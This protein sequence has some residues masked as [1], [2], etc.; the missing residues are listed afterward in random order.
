M[1]P[2]PNRV[3][4]PVP[5]LTDDAA[6]DAPK[7]AAQDAPTVGPRTSA[8]PD[9]GG[10][11][12]YPT[13]SPTAEPLAVQLDGR[14]SDALNFA[15]EQLESGRAELSEVVG[16]LANELASELNATGALL[17]SV[18]D[19]VIG[20]AELDL[21]RADEP[22]NRLL[23]NIVKAA[24]GELDTLMDG[25]RDVGLE[26]PWAAAHQAMQAEL[27]VF[28]Q[29]AQVVPALAKFIQP[30]AAAEPLAPTG[31][32]DSASV[33]V[34]AFAPPVA[35][36]VPPP[37]VHA[38]GY[39]STIVYA[40]LP[41]VA[42][43]PVPLPVPVPGYSPPPPPPPPGAPAGMCPPPHVTV[44]VA[45]APVFVM[46]GGVGAVPTAPAG[47]VPE[48][49]PPE[50]PVPPAPPSPLDPTGTARTPIQS[51]Y[52]QPAPSPKE[53]GNVPGERIPGTSEP[54]R[55]TPIGGTGAGGTPAPLNLPT[56]NDALFGPI[57]PKW[58][59]AEQ[60]RC[61]PVGGPPP[62]WMLANAALL[63]LPGDIGKD[64]GG[65]DANTF[66][67]N[68]GSSVPN[69]EA[70]LAAPPGRAGRFVR[71]VQELIGAS[72][73]PGLPRPL[74][75]LN[76]GSQLAA[77][78]FAERVT[79]A[80][81]SYLFQSELYQYQAANPQY[82]PT[83][84]RTD[85]AYLTAQIDERT[86]NAW[87]RANGNLPEP[88]RRTM[89]ANA[90]RLSVEESITLYRRGGIN[91][92]ELAKR[93]RQQGVLDPCLGDEYL[94]ITEAL[95]TQSDLVRFM[96]RDA[97]DQS[98]VDRY[99]LDT[100]F[101]QKYSGPLKKWGQ[102]LGVPDDYF[103]FVWRSHWE[104]PAY[105]QLREMFHRLRPDRA[106]LKK[107]DDTA[108]TYGRAAA[109]Q[110]LGPRPASVTR[111]DM[112]EALTIDDVAPGWV[113]RLIDVSYTPINR[114]DAL[115]AYQIGAFDDA[116]LLEAFLDLGYSPTDARTMLDFYKKEKGR[117]QRGQ[118]KV[119]SA[120]K[121]IRYYKSGGMPRAVALKYLE[122]TLGTV[123]DAEE[124]LYFADDELR[125]EFAQTQIRALRRAYFAGAINEQGVRDG[126]VRFGL[127]AAR[128]Q[129]MVD[130]WQ[131]ERD[132]K[133]K[134]LSA[135]KAM[136]M[137]KQGLMP[138]AEAE[139]RL[140]NL[141]YPQRDCDYLMARALGVQGE[142]DGLSDMQLSGAINDA[143]K[144]RKEANKKSNSALMRRLK[145]L[146]GEV[147]RIQNTLKDRGVP[148]DS[149]PADSEP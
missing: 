72:S 90:R 134:V 113:D 68:D 47:E 56:P 31:P 118:M 51:P 10:L 26:I 133:Y 9:G 106:A 7:A 15:T 129:L 144:S 48:C 139:Q 91:R 45:P 89:L 66:Q 23:F 149:E 41:A 34:P 62:K 105:T 121:V 27:P 100:D 126:F 63:D 58:S 131:L 77:A 103:R 13:L 43:L 93:M 20:A 67:W 92:A 84:V 21:S 101:E 42:P 3:P 54:P 64:L 6:Q 122:L 145:A 40:P 17:S 123:K 148:A 74:T 81:V 18:T 71:E 114:T 108:A 130:E 78:N 97:A 96:V 61:L 30:T 28:D 109:E 116:R 22:L 135:S 44:N 117:R 8:R 137:L 49:E 107:W 33:D 88:A 1:T 50:P 94:R 14:T 2:D 60:L 76:L 98:V 35:P 132:R 141:G 37:P 86:W 79:G 99:G 69:W 59:P 87:T 111:A 52:P 57:L 73:K 112:R 140:R 138:A 85:D 16:Q 46:P 136:E 36:P 5:P 65:S 55:S 11:S 12:D 80:P 95:P 119:M 32:T 24:N 53:R 19:E 147:A 115:R 124:A 102:A 70:S 82:L 39:P 146:V 120:G 75:A 4:L 110:N 127:D 25:A 125:A 142:G 38:S 83:Q 29:V 128:G 104:I 143:V